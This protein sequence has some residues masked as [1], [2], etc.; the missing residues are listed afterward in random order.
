MK[1]GI[2]KKATK[3]VKKGT[4]KATA[5]KSSPK[6][7]GEKGRGSRTLGLEVDQSSAAYVLFTGSTLSEGRL[8]ISAQAY[9]CDKPSRPPLTTFE[10]QV[11][12][13]GELLGLAAVF[14]NRERPYEGSI[15]ITLGTIPPPTTDPLDGSLVDTLIV[16]VLTKKRVS[17]P[18]R[19]LLDDEG[20]IAT[21]G[22][23]VPTAK[24]RVTRTKKAKK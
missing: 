20:I 7:K 15:H 19:G 18:L 12:F 10:Y 4:A 17:P 3:S 6:I 1:K 21:C 16:T 8:T 14:E 24:K 13:N 11:E 9:E 2:A 23:H 5:K 22:S